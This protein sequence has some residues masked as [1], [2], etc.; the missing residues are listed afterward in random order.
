[1]REGLAAFQCTLLSNIREV[2]N[3]SS[4]SAKDPQGD[5]GMAK[6]KSA[7]AYTRGSFLDDS[8]LAPN[9]VLC[10]EGRGVRHFGC[11]YYDFCLDKAAKAM[12]T[13]FTCAQCAFYENREVESGSP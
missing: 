1:M 2:I 9:P 5:G 12:W 7:T 6:E 13:G 11:L 8:K 3:T 10:R 4:S